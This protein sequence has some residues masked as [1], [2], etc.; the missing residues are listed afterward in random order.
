[1]IDSIEAN[2]VVGSSGLLA[3]RPSA[4]KAR[5]FYYATDNQTIY[6]D[7]GSAWRE[8]TTVGGV[9][10]SG[11]LIGGSSSEGVS[12]NAARADH[13]HALPLVTGSANG[14]MRA[15]DK[16]ILDAATSAPT[17]N[18]LVKN[19][20]NGR[21]QVANPSAAADVAP[22][23]YVDTAIATRAPSSHSHGWT[24]ITGKPTTFAA[25]AHTHPWAEVTGKPS[26]FA[27]DDHT[28]TTAEIASG[29][30]AAARLPLATQ[31]VLGAMSPTDKVKLD[32][33]SNLSTPSTL[34][35]TDA[36]GRFQALAPA[37]G[38]DVANK[39]Y[40]DAQVDTAA[41]ASHTH[42]W[43][44]V[45]GKPTTFAPSSHTHP[46]SQITGAP[47]TYTPSDH[48]HSTSD[49]TSGVFSAAR[50]PVATGS[51][52]GA[53]PAAMW[54]LLDGAT[55]APTPGALVQRHSTGSINVITGTSD[56]DAANKGYVD[57]R[58][59]TRAPSSHNHSA[60][61]ITS[62]TLSNDRLKNLGGGDT[63]LSLSSGR[64]EYRIA[65]DGE[66]YF[67]YDG[68]SIV[69]WDSNGSMN[70]GAVPWARITGEPSSYNPSS[71]N[72]PASQ[73]TSG[74]F[75]Y[76]RIRG[77]DQV[78][79][80]TATNRSVWVD[81]DGR[82]GQ[83]TSSIRFKKNVRDANLD[84]AAILRLRPRI[85]DRKNESEGMNELGLIAEEVEAEVPELA[86]Y[87]RAGVL[88]T[89]AYEKL[90]VA[91]LEVAKTQDVEIK[92]LHRRLE[93]AGL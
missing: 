75:A 19:D 23:A 57:D 2:V 76:E 71:H 38:N 59:N 34:M 55:Y 61:Q 33:A 8:L 64:G 89:V 25:T 50:L 3:A 12:L 30:F 82:F 45:T 31:S 65:T 41:P 44:S 36:N 26:T 35:M 6:Y 5:A 32:K 84:P 7:T 78:H 49:V 22:K 92:D 11:V 77:T 27:P 13:V 9:A 51:V 79:D 18:T 53:M 67:T 69:G 63:W 46:W 81:A 37:I 54:A 24:E 15:T 39:T 70:R 72:H 47:A 68:N 74:T 87:D 28:H 16:T 1:M 90:A 43:A 58:I 62:G 4:G 20:A 66:I 40:V 10:A 42:T 93:G 60:S 21:F 52:H 86:L 83:N 29:V 56:V 80:R 88:E 91:L 48:N 17:A 73:I 85:Y 14:A